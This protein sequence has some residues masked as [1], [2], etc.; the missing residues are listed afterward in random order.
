M[1]LRRLCGW[2]RPCGSLW[3]LRRLGLKLFSNNA[4][5]ADALAQEARDAAERTRDTWHLAF[6]LPSARQ[7]PETSAGLRTSSALPLEM[8]CDGRRPRL[9]RRSFSR[10][11]SMLPGAWWTV[12]TPTPRFACSGLPGASGRSKVWRCRYRATPAATP[13][14]PGLRRRP[15]TSPYVSTYPG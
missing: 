6:W 14:R 7:Q 10:S 13:T 5:R 12:A 9:I 11:W 1:L 3:W 4:A 2:G 8:P 15:R